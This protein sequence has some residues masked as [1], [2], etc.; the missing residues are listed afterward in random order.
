ML[1]SDVSVRRPVFAA[2][3]SLILIIIGLISANSMTIREYPDIQRPIVSISTNYRGAASDIVER[4]VT[5]VLEDQLAGISGIRK[6][7]S[8]SYDERST[9][10]LEFSGDDD[11]DDAANDVR[12]RVSG[13]LSMLPDEADPPQVSKQ[14]S[15]A[16]T[17]MWID[18]SSTTRSMMEVSDYAERYIVDALSVV[19]GV[20][21]IRGS[22]TRRPAMRIWVDPKRLAARGLT[23][24]DIEDALR[25]ENVQ[26]P[27]GR[28]ESSA[29]EFTLRTNTGFEST[30]DFKR[31]VL[32]EGND[33]YLIRLGEVA[34]IELAPENIRSYSG[35][36]GVAGV[37][38]GI[39]PQSQ[40]NI[41]KVNAGVIER[42]DSLQSS[43]PADMRLAV[44]MDN[45][46]FIRESL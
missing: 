29:R 18:V 22:G 14:D 30:D 13:V 19:D 8:V 32:A 28:L 25:R 11:I 20:A 35:S 7:S 23:V 42:I 5:Q 6:I 34:D 36:D 9:I 3:I 24:S 41:L 37:S 2:V 1:I 45:S 16:E 27:S 33:D 44:N 15:S 43:L 38:L 21:R 10:T 46:I 17:T 4:R 39:I 26:I 40:A 12:D 31:L